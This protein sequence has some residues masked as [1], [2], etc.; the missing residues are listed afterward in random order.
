MK[1]SLLRVALLVFAV[2]FATAGEPPPNIVVMLADDLGYG[3]PRCYNPASKIPTP[4]MDRLAAE[5]LRFTDAH[6]PAAVCTPTRYGF[7]TGRYAWRT[8][9]QNGSSGRNMRN[10]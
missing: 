9:L 5:G 7:L 4:N 3:D 6:T 1:R 8:R 2:A 10:R